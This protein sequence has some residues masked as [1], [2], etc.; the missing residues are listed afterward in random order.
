MDNFG[1]TPLHTAA[2]EGHPE[3][4]KISIDNNFNKN[5]TSSGGWTP[6]HH[7]AFNGHLEV[8]KILL[9]CQVQKNAEEKL[10]LYSTS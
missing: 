7:S 10:L 6:L 4:C 2:A 8:C 1:F 3:V 9:D 5:K